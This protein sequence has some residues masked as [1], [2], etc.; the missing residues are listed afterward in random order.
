MG[1]GDGT[2]K[3]AALHTRGSGG[4]ANNLS[5]G[6][7]NGDGIQDLVTDNSYANSVS[8]LLGNGNG[9]FKADRTT[10]L[11]VALQS[12]TVVDLNSDGISV[13]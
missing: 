5:L 8:V 7:M 9:T 4:N 2:F 12:P 11:G 3:A 6:D 10:P 1:N 13:S